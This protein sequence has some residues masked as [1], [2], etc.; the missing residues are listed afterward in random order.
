MI[1]SDVIP[2]PSGIRS[3]PRSTT[4]AA[5][6]SADHRPFFWQGGETAALLVHGFPGTPAEMRPIGQ[7]LH[8]MGWTVQGLLLPGFGPDFATIGS[9]TRTDWVASINAAAAAL[10]ASHRRVALVG[11]SM[12]AALCLD[13]AAQGSGDALLLFA[14]FWRAPNRLIDALYPLGRW[15]FPTIKPFI[16]ADFQDP[17]F[18]SALRRVVP[19]A[20]LDDAAVQEQIRNLKLPISVLGHVRQAGQLGYA[21]AP[22]VQQPGVIVQG[23]NDEL[24]TPALT[25]EVAARLPNLLALHEVDGGHDLSLL[26]GPAQ[27]EAVAAIQQFARTVDTLDPEGF[28]RQVS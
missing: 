25:R 26:A 6:Q 27:T 12:G 16:R 21:K 28:S 3:R 11:N 13:A 1:T 17:D 22:D 20:D 19:D 7:V 14:P 15:L 23:V 24:S 2:A 18:R 4:L 5:Y 10:H 8:S 9:R